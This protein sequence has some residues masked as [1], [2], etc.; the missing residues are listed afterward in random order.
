MSADPST[1]RYAVVGDPVAHSLSPLI[2]NGWMQR[3]GLD[4]HYA[5]VHLQSADAAA[6][7]RAMVQL[8]DGL[9]VTL[10]HK[11]AAL[12][13]AAKISPEA[14][15]VGAAN[16]LVRDGE[17]WIA[18]NTDVAGFEAALESAL[19][20]VPEN[21]NVLLI[22]AGGA[23]RAACV[24]LNRLGAKLIIANRSVDNA[25]ALAAELFHDADTASLADVERLSAGADIVVNSASLGHA[26]AAL[27]NL[28][29][30]LG[31]P[32]LDLTYG[33]AAAPALDA[34]AQSGWAPHD[35]L[36]MLVAQAAVS[37]H[38]WF[39]IHPDEDVALAACRAEVAKRQ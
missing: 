21:L 7:L 11:I 4:A 17:Q 2:H 24:S 25:K 10:P 1:R 39:G 33:K 32:F 29:E 14:K 26:G 20:H 30:G 6:D 19:G 35:G 37:F 36:T 38:H 34:A 13:A 8:Y 28:A 27:P 23:A 5:R 15:A 9:N 12:N 31:R 22:G 18:H 3:Y 16:T